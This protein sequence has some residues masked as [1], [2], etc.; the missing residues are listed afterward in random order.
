MLVT[1]RGAMRLHPMTIDGPIESFS[2]FH[3]INC[4]KGFLYFNKQG[5]LRISVLPTY[6]SYD[7][8]WPVRKIPLRCTVHYVSYHVESKVYAVC[9]S[10]KDPCTR[11]PRMTGEEKEFETIDRGGTSICISLSP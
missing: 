4:P 7:A 6:L 5:E 2:P 3:N 11:I 9:T 1:S 10:V 8:P